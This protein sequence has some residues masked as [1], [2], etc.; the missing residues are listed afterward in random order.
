MHTGQCHCGAVKIEIRGEPAAIGQCFCRDCRRTLGSTNAL[1]WFVPAEQLKLEGRAVCRS[2]RQARTNGLLASDPKTHAMKGG[3]GHLVTNYFCANCG[4]T[5]YRE[6]EVMPGTL[7]VKA[8]VLDDVQAVNQLRPHGE[9]F[10]RTR[11]DWVTPVAGASQKQ[12]ML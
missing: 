4:V 9:I 12:E 7:F 11:P 3:S 1:N 6:G 8:G 5:L 2:S 10:V